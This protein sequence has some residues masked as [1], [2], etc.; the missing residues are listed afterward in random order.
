MKKILYILI[1]ILILGGTPGIC[2]DLGGLK[3]LKARL[4]IYH[5]KRLQFMI[6]CAVM[7]R[8]A[9]KIFADDA[10]IDIVK[11]NVDIN[12]I[13]YYEDI[14]LYKLGAANSD[15]IDFWKNKN[16]TLGF[17]TSSKA[18]ILQESKVASG[19]EKVYFRSPQ[20]DLDG[21]GFTANFD[22][23]LIKVLNDVNI[24]IRMKPPEKTMSGTKKDIV[25]VKADSMIMDMQKELVTLIGNV[26]VNEANFDIFCSKLLLDLK[27]QDDAK[28]VKK[29]E[30]SD[31]DNGL[32]PTGVSQ[33]IC[34]G[35]V[36][37]IRKVS[38]AELKKN[39]PQEAF[40]DKAVYNT[41]HERITLTGKS[42]S[43]RRGTDM[44]SGQKIV[45]WKNS[46]RLKAYKNCLVEVSDP[47]AKVPRKTE[48]ESDFIDFDYSNNLGLFV[49]HVRVKNADFRLNC[50]KMA[51]HLQDRDSNKKD[52]V[53]TLIAS[54]GKKDLRE[55]VCMGN[56]IIT[57]N[58]LD[59]SGKDERAL[60]GRAVYVLKDNKIILSGKNP[61]II[62]GRDSVSGKIMHV[63]LDQNRLKVLKDSK[64]TLEKESAKGKTL[65][66]SHSS[67]LNYGGNELAFSGKVKITDP[68]MNLNCDNMKIYLDEPEKTKK[69]T[70]V[71]P[72]DISLAGPGSKKDVRKIVC[73]GSVRAADP[74]ASVN[75]ERMVVTFKDS[76]SGTK[77]SPLGGIGGN[78]K[79]EV[80]LIKCY[81]KVQIANKPEQPDVKPTIATA[82]KAIL[83]IPGNVAD[84]VGKVEIEESRFNLTC[85]KMKIFAK[86]ITKEQA[87]INQ[88]VNQQMD[89]MVP[90]H[91]GIGD[92]KE[93]TKII[94]LDNVVMKRKLPNELQKAT[95]DKAVYIV[96]E[97]NVTMTGKDEEHK[98]TLQRGPTIME[99]KKIILWTDSEKLEIQ[100]GV[101][102]NF[103]PSG[104]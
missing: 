94:C 51:I 5:K 23:R 71:K 50:N 101:L 61:L 70:D 79:R 99:G 11:K 41:V 44:I 3:I 17:I 67:D 15:I 64:I 78:S 62:S 45:I 25:K 76:V 43:I 96:K 36:K 52:I 87:A 40:A 34:L 72:D 18:T 30:K 49:G 84:L 27:K 88:K 46:E 4:P 12:D 60:A 2:D 104:L 82:N 8:Q 91:V 102:K 13:K 83:N 81:D 14:K 58:R 80:D 100:E 89:D 26:K 59:A 6:F 39:G 47:N 28:Q 77:Q 57:R 63:W 33:I 90:Q 74:R 37:I 1:T 68:Q 95:G 35:D 7:T 20:L 69:E 16:N 75:C 86:D 29:K 19:S 93:L 54:S 73:T 21:V 32:D 48:L 66:K 31:S 9:N 56:V 38:E 98:P 55:I 103:D 10:V 85:E 92:A 24:I 65:I 22:T 97:H 42:P 53:K